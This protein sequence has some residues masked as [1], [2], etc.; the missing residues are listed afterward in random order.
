MTPPNAAGVRDAGPA[1]AALCASQPSCRDC[2]H[3]TCHRHPLR[4]SVRT[5]LRRSYPRLGEVVR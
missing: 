1:P 4:A 3:L 5:K 2:P